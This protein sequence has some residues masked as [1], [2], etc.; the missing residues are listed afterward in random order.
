[1]L[2]AAGCF[3]KTVSDDV[4]KEIDI[5]FEEMYTFFFRKR[6]ILLHSFFVDYSGFSCFGLKNNK[7]RNKKKHVKVKGMNSIFS[8]MQKC[9]AL[10]MQ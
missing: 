9:S 1:M 3:I 10:R 2:E 4:K 8:R 6:K 7:K 5:Y